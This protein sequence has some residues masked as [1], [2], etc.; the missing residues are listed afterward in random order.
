MKKS[1]SQKLT[2]VISASAAV[3]VLT[4]LLI[5]A[6]MQSERDRYTVISIGKNSETSENTTVVPVVPVESEVTMST[7]VTTVPLCTSAAST[8]QTT[9]VSTDT[10]PVETFLFLDINNA[11]AAEL[12]AL[13]GI[14]DTLAERI[15]QYREGCGRFLNIEQ[16]T[17]VNGIGNGIFNDIREHIY[18]VD[19]IYPDP[20]PDEAP[21]AEVLPQP[22]VE[23]EADQPIYPV[24]LNTAGIDELMTLPGVD[25]SMAEN[26]IKLRDEIGG[27]KNTYELLLVEGISREHAAEL[28]DYTVVNEQ[29]AVQ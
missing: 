24:D 11:S 6:F 15:V 14:G 5:S 29:P 16:I 20:V 28:T 1:G 22:E 25:S 8:E 17:G 13:P 12:A 9:C 23:E 2:V 4:V 27:F 18:V 7:T 21:A 10:V 3:I 19:P 26:I